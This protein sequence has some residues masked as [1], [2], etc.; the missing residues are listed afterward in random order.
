[1]GYCF[2]AFQAHVFQG[3]T[4]HRDTFPDSLKSNPVL[5]FTALSSTLAGLVPGPHCTASPCLRFHK[6]SSP[7][8][9]FRVPVDHLPPRVPPTKQDKTQPLFFTTASSP[10]NSTKFVKLSVLSSAPSLR[11]MVIGILLKRCCGKMQ[12]HT[13]L[14]GHICIQIACEFKIQRIV[15]SLCLLRGSKSSLEIFP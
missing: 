13:G 11:H 7:R 4:P 10:K 8:S 14:S 3:S 12:R 1:M 9:A 15:F 6:V 5:C 2:K